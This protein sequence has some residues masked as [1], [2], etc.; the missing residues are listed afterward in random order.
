KWLLYEESIRVPIIIHAPGV[1][2]TLRGKKLDN[3]ALNIDVA[4]TILDMAGIPIPP[5]MD[6]VSLYPHLRGQQAPARA[7]FF[8]EH[9]GVIDVETPIP[10]SRGVRTDEWKYIR[11]VNVEPEVEEMYHIKVDPWESHNLVDD[12]KYMEIKKQLRERYD[13]YLHT[14]QN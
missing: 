8:M 9:V 12:A 2:D 14:L 13:S 5:D 3:L 11:Y 6:G 4:P 1:L 10:D 7:D